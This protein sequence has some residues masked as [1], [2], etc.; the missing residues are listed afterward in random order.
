MHIEKNICDNILG[1][2]LDIPGKNKDSLKARLDLKKMNMHDKLRA[3]LI[4]DKYQVPKAPLNLTLSERRQVVA[5]LSSLR[6]L[7][8][9]SSNISRCV[10]LDDGRLLGMKGH[11]CHIFM[12]DLLLPAL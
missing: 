4:G 8:G 11:D 12:Q 6:I 10:T 1:T 5:L 9:Y 3:K 7:D 2:L